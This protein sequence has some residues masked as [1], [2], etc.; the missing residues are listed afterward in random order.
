[1]AAA[2]AN[3]LPITYNFNGLM[4]DGSTATGVIALNVY[5]YESIP[6]AI[7][8]TDGVFTGYAYIV[9]TD[10]SS[11][12]NPLDTVLVLS[13]AGYNGYLHLEFQLSLASGQPD[14]LLVGGASYECSTYG[15]VNGNCGTRGIQRFFTQG[16]AD[17]VPEPASLALLGA[18]LAGLAARRRRQI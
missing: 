13:R 15:D 1:M 3:A 14:A 2:P 10:P 12:N 5:G 18:G 6:T 8:T 4:D 7:T 11:I 17:P 16:S 9:G